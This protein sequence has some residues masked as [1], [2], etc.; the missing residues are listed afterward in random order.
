MN[1]VIGVSWPVFIGLTVILFGGASFMTGQATAKSWRPISTLVFYILLLGIGNRFLVFALFEGPLLSLTGYAV[2]T[3]VL[4]V[5]GLAAHQMTKARKM[6]AQ[7][8]WLY[9]RSGPFGWR[10]RRTA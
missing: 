10:E 2:H 1:E 6:V 3:A 7:Y 5:I 4:M 8:P 9:E